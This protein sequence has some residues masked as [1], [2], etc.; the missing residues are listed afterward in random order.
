MGKDISLIQDNLYKVIKNFESIKNLIIIFPNLKLEINWQAFFFNLLFSIF[1]AQKLY[2]Q[3]GVG[4]SADFLRLEW[5]DMF[6]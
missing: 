5:Y 1:I 6:S 4:Q 3:F 2:I